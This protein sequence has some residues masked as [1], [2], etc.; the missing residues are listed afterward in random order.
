[1]TKVLSAGLTGI[2]AHVVEVEI[3]LRQ[4]SLPAWHMVG[5]ADSEVKESKERVISALHNSGFAPSLRK[6]TINLAPADTRKE[7][8]AYDLPI[9]VGILAA[10]GVLLP[11]VAFDDC[12]ILG[13]LGL[14]GDVRPVRGILP[15][16]I[17][18]KERGIAKMLVPAP[19]VEEAAVVAGVEVYGFSRLTEVV[20]FLAGCGISKPVSTCGFPTVP[21]LLGSG[22][23]FADIRGQF[24]ARRALEI[25]AAG[26]HNI[27]LSG[28]PGT[29]KTMLASRI[30][31]IL[32][33]L[34]FDE[35]LETSRV[36]S[37]MGLLKSHHRLL[38]ERPFRSPHHSVSNSGLI[39]GG[40]IPKP[41]EVSLAHNG[42]LFLD[43]L[44]EFHKHVLELLR[45]PIE[46]HEV[47]IAR[48]MATLTFP[49]RFILVA[50][51]NP[52]PCGYRGHPRVTCVCTPPQIQRYRSRLSGPLLDRI[53]L[54][55]EVPPLTFTDLRGGAP[56]EDS[57]TIAERVSRVR[58]IQRA[59]FIGAG[60]T[61]NSQMGPGLIAKHC[62]LCPEGESVLRAAMEKYQLSARAVNRILRVARTVADLA[63]VSNVAVEHVL[64][65]AQYRS[66][67]RKGTL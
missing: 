59:R 64:E 36:Y 3:D 34:T 43:E 7:G 38:T 4:Q 12:V 35:S 1:M 27:L 44:T 47:T 40:S 56:G 23:D 32:P 28:P 45:Q 17:L 21:A 57:R 29:G 26:S 15:A 58:E 60:I 19:N 30:P 20:E 67:D 10:A 5:L 54:Q 48:A 14:M 62:H 18:A 46:S 65:A 2:D 16:A 49:A 24:Q 51:C 66:L 39:G 8:T 9:A 42:V 61:L 50:S 22:P 52:C 55:V 13:E 63:G 6:V 53:D 37:V 33:P 31:T 11:T 41:G 25:A